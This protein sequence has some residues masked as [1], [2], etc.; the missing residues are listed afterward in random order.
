MKM[1]IGHPS[2]SDAIFG[3]DMIVFVSQPLQSTSYQ[4]AVERTVFH[5]GSNC[6]QIRCPDCGANHELDAVPW[7]EAVERWHSC[8]A[9]YALACPVCAHSAPIIDWT[10]LEFDWVFGTLGFGFNNWMIDARLAA[11]LGNV[12]GHRTK[13]VYEHI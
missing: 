11:E 12:L 10:F 2:P 13:V 8:E 1:V 9:D 7:R 6:N 5:A 3:M 4:V